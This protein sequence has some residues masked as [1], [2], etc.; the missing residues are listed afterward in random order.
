V[1]AY[2]VS[3][4][5]IE[6]TYLLLTKL[7][8]YRQITSALLLNRNDTTKC[9]A[10]LSLTHTYIQVKEPTKL[11]CHAS[12]FVQDIF[13]KNF[14]YSRGLKMTNEVGMKFKCQLFNNLLHLFHLNALSGLGN[15]TCEYQTLPLY[16]AL[17]LSAENKDCIKPTTFNATMINPIY[18]SPWFFP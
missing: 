7:I 14:M 17:T 6:D 9:F 5:C 16:Y 15:K 12:T 8:N 10:Y 1:P 11:S 2:I 3:D 18:I 13:W 4:L